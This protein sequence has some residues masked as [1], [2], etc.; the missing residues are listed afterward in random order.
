MSSSFE[1]DPVEH[2]TAGAVGEPGHRVFYIQAGA[3]AQV[4]TLV[5]EKEQ[6]QALATAI[7]R[8]LAFLPDVEDEGPEVLDEE[9]ELQQPLLPEWRAGGM[10]LDYVEERDRIAIMIHE[11]TEEDDEEAERAVMR[12]TATRAQA[13]AL[14]IRGEEVCAAGRPRCRVCGLPMDPEGHICPALNGHRETQA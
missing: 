10:A 7:A 4:V 1:L 13:R 2:L 6:V 5:M 9:L 12:V 3:Q 8:L 14:A 11:A